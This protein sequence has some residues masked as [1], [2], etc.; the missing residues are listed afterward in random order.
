MSEFVGCFSLLFFCG[1]ESFFVQDFCFEFF[2]GLPQQLMH[3]TSPLIASHSAPVA[4]TYGFLSAQTPPKVNAHCS[5]SFVVGRL[6]G[7]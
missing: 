5:V 7:G 4:F 6:V 1:Y 2:C 3:P